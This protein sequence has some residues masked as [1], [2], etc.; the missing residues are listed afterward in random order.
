MKEEQKKLLEQFLPTYQ[1]N[2]DGKFIWLG[3]DKEIEKK[4]A[5]FKQEFFWYFTP[6]FYLGKDTSGERVQ[7]GR[8]PYGRKWRSKQNTAFPSVVDLVTTNEWIYCRNKYAQKHE[9][10]LERLKKEPAFGVAQNASDRKGKMAN[11]TNEQADLLRKTYQAQL[12]ANPVYQEYK[13][14][15]R[16]LVALNTIIR[17]RD[18]KYKERGKILN[19]LLNLRKEYDSPEMEKNFPERKQRYSIR[20]AL[21]SNLTGRER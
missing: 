4:I 5:N 12:D 6:Y 20:A 8:L 1:V 18:P 17:E 13:A 2:P 3:D 11:M 19:A 9:K 10:C 21:R 7:W 16:I 14:S 15:R